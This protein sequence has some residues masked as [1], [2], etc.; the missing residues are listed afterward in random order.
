[1]NDSTRQPRAPDAKGHLATWLALK[2]RALDD[3]AY[4]DVSLLAVERTR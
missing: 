1:M 4:D 2:D 3:A